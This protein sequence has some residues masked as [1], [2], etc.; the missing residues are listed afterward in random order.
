MLID[1]RGLAR[2]RGM[3]GLQVGEV[4]RLSEVRQVAM[5]G[6]AVELE[7]LTNSLTR[8]TPLAC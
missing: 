6:G 8:R 5:A 3:A 7:R 1:F 2:M 4:T